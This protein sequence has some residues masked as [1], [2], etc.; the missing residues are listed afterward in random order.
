MNPYSACP[1]YA[2]QPA[3]SHWR[4]AREQ[5]G[6]SA[7]ILFLSGT[8]EGEGKAALQPRKNPDFPLGGMLGSIEGAHT[9]WAEAKQAGGGDGWVEF[10][11]T[12]LYGGVSF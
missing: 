5:N 10:L 2:F 8:N 6:N 3:P 9:I 4:N 11:F 1:R 12:L 7:S